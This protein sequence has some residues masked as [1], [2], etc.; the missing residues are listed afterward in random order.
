[1]AEKST[2]MG[3]GSLASGTNS[4]ATG[5]NSTASAAG[6]VASGSNA[7][8]S[9]TN[10]T[11]LGFGARA[12]HVNS[13]AIGAHAQTTRDNQM[14]FGTRTNTYTMS[15]ITSEASKAA[16]T[17]PL[18]V[19]TTDANGNLASDGGAFQRQIDALGKR[20]GELA[21]GIAIALALDA[22][23]LQSGQSFA[24]R[25]GYGNFDGSSALGVAAAGLI[26]KGSF[27]AGS[28]VTLDGGVGFGTSDG[29]VAGKAGLTVGW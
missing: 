1:M 5:A 29:T 23:N 2:A 17:G 27:G 28:T 4:T 21:E 7:R 26:D 16:Q 22:P 15:G 24:L 14:A 25:M 8:A 13:A 20:D 3:Q 10:A 9:A 19:V 12:D 18:E 6:T 11:A